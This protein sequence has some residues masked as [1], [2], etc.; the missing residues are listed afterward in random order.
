M[1]D[2]VAK[3]EEILKRWENLNFLNENGYKF[4][5]ENNW[6]YYDKLINVITHNN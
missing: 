3:N 1:K 4:E 5:K 2:F 6:I